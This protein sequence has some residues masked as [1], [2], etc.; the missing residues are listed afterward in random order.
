[1]HLYHPLFIYVD[2]ISCLNTVYHC[3][4][5]YAGGQRHFVTYP[6][7]RLYI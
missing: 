3:T 7:R 6:G 2:F 1:M 4:I 5:R